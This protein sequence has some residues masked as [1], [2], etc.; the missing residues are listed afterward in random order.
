M[1]LFAASCGAHIASNADTARIDA[2]FDGLQTYFYNGTFSFWK[3]CGQTGGNGGA[4]NDFNCD[5]AK[6]PSG[7]CEECFR[8]WMAGTVGTLV[9]L[10]ALVPAHRSSSLTLAVVDAMLLRSPYTAR[11]APSWAYIDDYLWYVLMWLRVA[12]WKG[13]ETSLVDEAA[14]T[15]DLMWSF[16]ADEACGGIVW[17]YP[18]VDPRKNAITALEAVQA[19]AQLAAAYGAAA[20]PQRAAEYAGRAR[21]LWAWF[22]S[23]PLLSS[24]HLVLDNV[25]GTPHGKMQCCNGTSAGASGPV[26][27]NAARTPVW[28]YNQGMLLGALVDLH[29]LTANATLLSLGARTLDAVVATL[30]PDGVLAETKG[31]T[32]PAATC[33]AAHDP[34]A[35]A[36][37]DIF[38]FKGVFF[39]ELPRFVAA[40]AASGAMSAA[41]RGAARRLVGASAAAAWA[42]RVAPPFPA[43]DVCD[44]F[45]AAAPVGGPP[46][47]TWDFRALPSSGYNCM[48]A[49]TQASA[50]A[51]FVAEL[52]LNSSAVAYTS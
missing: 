34:S 13:N 46:K 37:G 21:A 44:E 39:R 40:A 41:Q 32:I 7:F 23:T 16:G 26:C 31:L 22:E 17:L 18:D 35:T 27:A 51:L 11:Y 24:N 8:W 20:Q 36:G 10:N 1:L 6:D 29:A 4:F 28:S 42:S 5:C 19:A 14:A 30:A 2:A 48:D 25:T 47:F 15:F 3:A 50:L 45:G 9:D 38:S 52:A 43:S 33:D 12:R 49:R